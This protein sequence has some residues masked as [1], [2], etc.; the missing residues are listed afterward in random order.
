MAHSPSGYVPPENRN[1]KVGANC[2]FYRNGDRRK[3]ASKIV[4]SD[5]IRNLE[6]VKDELTRKFN[7]KDSTKTGYVR[8]VYTPSTGTPVT[9][10]EDFKNGACYVAA[11]NN[12][13]FVALK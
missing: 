11:L 2:H 13:K 3:T 9:R 7:S 5:R 10:L 6:G 4:I 1:L 12:E 8:N